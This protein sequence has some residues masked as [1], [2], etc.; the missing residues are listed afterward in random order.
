MNLRS[1][2]QAALFT[3]GPRGHWGLP[4]LFE[5]EPGTAK[6]AITE[7]VGVTTGLHVETII[8][9]IRAPEDFGGIPIPSAD[10]KSLRR[11]PDSWVD[12]VCKAERAVVFF[13]EFNHSPPAVL[14]AMLRV[15]NERA[16][17][18]VLLPKGVRFI[19]AQNALSDGGGGD[20]TAAMANRFGHMKWEGVSAEEWCSW[21]LGAEDE[22]TKG[23]AQ[24]EESRV[25]SA[26]SAPYAKARGS[27]AGFIKR[28]G[29]LLHKKPEPNSP[30]AS[31]AWPSRRTWELAARASAGAD[32]HALTETDGDEFIAAFIGEGAASEWATW[33]RMIDLP[34][35][36]DVLDGRV[37]FDHDGRRLDR[38]EA[39]LMSCASFVAPKTAVKRGERASNLWKLMKPIAEASTDVCVSAFEVLV[40]AGLSLTP[41][42]K[43]AAMPVLAK[44]A[45]VLTAS[46]HR[47]TATKR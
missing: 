31:K 33:K 19:A 7:G 25:E 40:G 32:V 15:I 9:S 45:P 26:W 42:T 39:V 16:S 38:T 5:G 36:E 24:R 11:L 34:D 30:Q 41:E 27:V 44:V 21:L 2:I 20:L 28:R 22:A 47:A 46:G 3:P 4:L 17:G 6:T 37:K 8:A 35:P 1:V 23:D 43:A 13:D 12:R 14:A 10:G 29:D 18:D